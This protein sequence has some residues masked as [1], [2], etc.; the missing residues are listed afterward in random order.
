MLEGKD[1]YRFYTL[2]HEFG[3]SLGLEHPFEARDGDLF[4]DNPDPWSSAYPEDT[5]M[6]YRS[7]RNGSWPHFFSDNDLNALIEV[8]GAEARLLGDDSDIIIGAAYRDIFMG[9]GGDDELRGRRGGDHIEG[10]LGD[11]QVMG[12]KGPDHLFGGAGNDL[13]FGGYGHDTINSGAGNDHIRGGHGADLFT[14]SAGEDVIIDFC[15]SDHDRINILNGFEYFL[16]QEDQHLV[17]TTEIGFTILLNVDYSE[18]LLSEGI[19]V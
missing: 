18:F 7:P 8:W 19:I 1:D 2:I 14:L 12:G 13:I 15:L 9:A 11:D 4:N 17:F 10:G 5:L 16:S 3:H 6:A